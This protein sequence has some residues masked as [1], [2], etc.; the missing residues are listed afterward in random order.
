MTTYPNG[1][2][3]YAILTEA[4]AAF[5]ALPETSP[6]AIAAIARLE[7]AE[8]AYIDKESATKAA[9][10]AFPAGEFKDSGEENAN[11]MC[12]CERAFAPEDRIAFYESCLTSAEF[13]RN[14]TPADDHRP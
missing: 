8:S 10:E 13:L 9:W 4:R 6:D 5:D 7:A 14:D 2:P 11:E 1:S 3:E 12:Y